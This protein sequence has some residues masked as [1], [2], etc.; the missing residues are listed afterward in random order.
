MVSRLRFAGISTRASSRLRCVRPI[1]VVDN[2][3][4]DKNSSGAKSD[5]LM[6]PVINKNNDCTVSRTARRAE[7]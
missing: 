2:D 4:P 1:A 6:S 5:R 3:P 7:T